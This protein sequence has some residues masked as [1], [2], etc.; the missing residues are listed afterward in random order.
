MHGLKLADQKSL[1]KQPVTVLVGIGTERAAQLERL[2]ILTVEDLLLHR[3]RRYEDRRK[4]VRIGEWSQGQTAMIQGTVTAMGVK[5]YQHHR[6]S[7]FELIL[8]DGSGRLRCRWWNMPYLEQIYRAGQTL[9]VFGKLKDVKPRIV[10]HP[11]VEAAEEG[12]DVSLHVHRI[13]PIY[14]LTEG[15]SQRWLRALI[16]RSL[17][18]IEGTVEEPF[19][20][21]PP[22]GRMTR[23]Q[24]LVCLHFP[25]ELADADQARRRLA[26]DE[27]IVLQLE[28]MRRRRNLALKASAPSCAGDNRCIRPFL[29]RLGFTLTT[30]QTR[31]LR[32]IR[33]DLGGPVPMRRLLQ[34][35]VGSG[36]TVVAACAALM[37][38]ESGLNA[39][40]MAPTEILAEQH[41]KKFRDW[42]EPLGLTVGL[43]TGERKDSLQTAGSTSNNP[44]GS[45]RLVVGTHALLERPF[46]LESIG[47][48]II[49]EQHKFGVAQRERLVRKGCYP[50]LLVMTA[51]PIPRTLALTLYGDLEVS[52]IDEMPSGRGTVRTFLRTDA[53]LSKVWDFVRTKLRE[54]RQAYVVCPRL[55]EDGAGDL[56]AVA[57]EYAGLQERMK[58]HRVGLVHG[59][60][61]A[62]AKIQVMKEFTEGHLDVLLATTVVEVGLDVPN[63]TVLVVLNAEHYGLAQLHQLRG[64]IGRGACE[65]YCILVGQVRTEAARQRLQSFCETTDGFQIA[66]IDLKLR[67]PGEML[68]QQQSGMP[69][70]R[71]ADLGE[72]FS[73]LKEARAIAARLEMK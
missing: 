42:M 13:V 22:L 61:P 12:D 63:A 4:L 24:A 57:T 65:A 68:G 6:K 26:L 25:G 66:E 71:F 64:R 49:D 54:G 56:K 28:F 16:W 1:M 37:T 58:P 44:P 48:V 5:W 10:D 8:E 43:W 31:V 52:T 33:Q 45:P 73:L 18:R 53:A 32:E 23:A 51:T 38:L 70:F 69:R 29:R 14:P 62:E 7:V 9:V 35:D 41:H 11:E 20:G 55:E 3:P 46:S 36:K 59:Q 67:G 2:G 47:L 60:L 50:H 40:L 19:I 15:V 17:S 27:L 21:F 72:D 34:G 39:V 30:A